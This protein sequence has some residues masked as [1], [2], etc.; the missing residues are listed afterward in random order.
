M[1][2][3]KIDRLI[4]TGKLQRM[5]TKLISAAVAFLTTVVFTFCAIKPGDFNMIGYAFCEMIFSHNSPES[6]RYENAVVY[7]FDVLCGSGVFWI[8]YVVAVG[9][10]Q[11]CQYKK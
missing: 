8:V 7:S 4:K 3:Y 2:K 11:S 6:Q 1:K 5:K 9:I 10:Q